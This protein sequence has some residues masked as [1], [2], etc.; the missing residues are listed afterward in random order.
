MYKKIIMALTL[1]SSVVSSVALATNDFDSI[2]EAEALATAADS[3]FYLETSIATKLSLFHQDAFGN[4]TL[5]TQ[6]TVPQNSILAVNLTS[7]SST[8]NANW[9]CGVRIVDVMDDNIRESDAAEAEDFCIQSTD[10]KKLNLLDTSNGRNKEAFNNFK[11]TGKKE[12]L[13]V[14]G[15]LVANQIATGQN[16]LYYNIAVTPKNGIISPLKNCT[17]GCLQVTSEFGMRIHPVFKT[18]RMHK[19]IDLQAPS[20]SPVVSVYD[21]RVLATRTERNAKTRKMKGYG[22]YVI[23]IHPQKQIETL[24]AHL[25]AFK[26]QAGKPVSQG[27]LIALSGNTGIGTAPHL[28]FEVHVS[29]NQSSIAVNPRKYI[30]QLLNTTL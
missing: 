5:S 25:S 6:V 24:Y 20:G 7:F 4:N 22:N 11:K 13:A 2:D 19:G 18:R 16:I 23:V 30:S 3:R 15:S 28:H 14:L 12:E 9:V 17:L 10:A 26:T 8:G 21:G 1:I 29:K 27:E